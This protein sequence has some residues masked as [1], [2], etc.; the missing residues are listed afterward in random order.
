VVAPLLGRSL[1]GGAANTT[2]SLVAPGSL[3]G[4]RLNQ[5]DLRV[6]KILTF[7]RVRTQFAFDLYNALN[8]SAVQTIN[9]T[10]GPSWQTPT[11]IITARLAKV[12]MQLDF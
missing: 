7:G 10:F 12:G 5:M 2:L 1:S 6:A 11:S 3:Y 4:E 8:S 9:A